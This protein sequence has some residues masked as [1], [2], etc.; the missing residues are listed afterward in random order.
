MENEKT[1][2]YIFLE[3]HSPQEAIEAVKTTNGY[4]LDKQHTF[5]VNLLSDFDK[6][7]KIQDHLEPPAPKP[8]QDAGNIYNYA[9]NP[10]CYNQY[11]FYYESIVSLINN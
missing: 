2:G 4:K 7:E 10:H 9:M 1:K 6:Y 8:Y 3:F 11:R 5:A